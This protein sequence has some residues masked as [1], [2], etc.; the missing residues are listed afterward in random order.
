MRCLNFRPFARL[1]TFLTY[2]AVFAS[3]IAISGINSASAQQDVIRI[4]AIVNDEI[5]SVFDLEN[6]VRLVAMSTNSSQSAEALNRLAPQV[7]RQMIDERLQLQE[8]NKFN[9]RVSSRELN[10]TI[11][12]LERQNNMSPGQIWTLLRSNNIDRSALEMQIRAKISWL[13]LINRRIRRQISVG[14]EEINEE[15]ARLRS[16]RGQAQLQVFEI[17]LSVDLPDQEQQIRQT[18]DRLISQI[19]NGARFDAL[20]R[21]FSQ[22]T[23]AGRGGNLGW[24]TGSELDPELAAA[25]SVM[26][27]GQISQPIRTLTGYY[28]LYLVNRRQGDAGNK[29][30]TT[31][32]YRQMTAPVPPGA[33]PSEVEAQR[34]LAID[35]ASEANSCDELLQ[36]ARRVG[37]RDMEAIHEV[38]ISALTTWQR[39]ILLNNDIG[40]AGPPTQTPGGFLIIMPCERIEQEAG[41]PSAKVLE[42][43]MTRER[44]ELMAQKFMRDLR[45]SA[46]VDLRQ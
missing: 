12:N 45:R 36:I 10:G 25:L 13:K 37:A 35:V 17:F 23:T 14:Q 16:L 2:G 43:R 42:E 30:D 27:P 11:A 41:I 40:K 29:S 39:N 4:A 44:V 32:K 34:Q 6:R 15:I 21:E 19:V 38:S 22:S 28:I 1:I 9:I 8:A 20:A 33:P 3:T 18:A 46:Y 26:Q 7:L 5:I 24:I 31:I